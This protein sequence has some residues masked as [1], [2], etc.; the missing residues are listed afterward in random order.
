[1]SFIGDTEGSRLVCLSGETRPRF[2]ILF[3]GRYEKRPGEIIVA[4]EFIAEKSYKARGKRMTTYEVKE[5]REI[6]PLEAGE[7]ETTSE[8]E[9]GTVDFEITNPD[10]LS[11][12]SQMTI[13]F[14]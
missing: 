8:E 7:K 10:M 9:E 6:E 14:E 1:M 3:G 13:D 12:E 4:D 11:G 5:I 2:E